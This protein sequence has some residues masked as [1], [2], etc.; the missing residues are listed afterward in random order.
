[1]IWFLLL[2]VVPCVISYSMVVVAKTGMTM[3]LVFAELDRQEIETTTYDSIRHV[4]WPSFWRAL[5]FPPR[6]LWAVLTGMIQELR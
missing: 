1:M 2:L 6:A 5:I 4:L 3:A